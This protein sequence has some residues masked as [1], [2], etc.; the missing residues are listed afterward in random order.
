MYMPRD[1]M[2]VSILLKKKDFNCPVMYLLESFGVDHFLRDCLD[3]NRV[4]TTP[5]FAEA[6]C[7]SEN[8]TEIHIIGN[9]EVFGETPDSHV[10]AVGTPVEIVGFE[11]ILIHEVFFFIVRRFAGN[12]VFDGGRSEFFNFIFF[13]DH[14]VAVFGGGGAD[15]LAASLDFFAESGFEVL[16]SFG[17]YL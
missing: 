9:G 5:F 12:E 2:F 8:I 10:S 3:T 16:E 14:I 15:V 17:G 6:P 4:E 1:F 13:G 7:V 11:I